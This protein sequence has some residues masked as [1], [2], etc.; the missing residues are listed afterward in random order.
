MEIYLTNVI[1]VLCGWWLGYKYGTRNTNIYHTTNYS[2][3]FEKLVV[4]GELRWSAPQNTNE[5]KPEQPPTGAVQN[6]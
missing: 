1:C 2:G 5:A 6:G 4:N 3:D